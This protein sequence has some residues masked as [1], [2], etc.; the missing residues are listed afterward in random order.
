[1]GYLL[2]SWSPVRL[3]IP[4][5]CLSTRR[6]FRERGSCAEHVFLGCRP[7]RESGQLDSF[8]GID[9]YLVDSFTSCVLGTSLCSSHC[10]SA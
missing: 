8:L 2:S 3:H 9:V 4:L 10:C 6:S 7:E 1:M 5:C